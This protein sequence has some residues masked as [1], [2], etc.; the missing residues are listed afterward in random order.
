MSNTYRGSATPRAG[1]VI[2]I[3][4]DEISNAPYG[5]IAA[6]NMQDAINELD[7]EKV[8]KAGD[9]MTGDLTVP[10][11]V[12]AGN[13]DGRD[14]SVD[15]TKLDGIEAL[16]DVTDVTNVTAAGALMDSEVDAGIKTLVLPAS[17][18]ISTFGASLVDDAA[19]S[20]ARTTLGLGTLAVEN[21]APITQGGTG[22]PTAQAAIDA[23]SSVSAATN[24]HVLTKDT[25]TG[26]AIF[27]VVSA[28]VPAGSIGQSE[29]DT[30]EL[31]PIVQSVR[32]DDGTVA[33]GTTILP[34]D[35][36]IPQNTEGDEYLTVTITPRE[37]NNK[38]IIEGLVHVAHSTTTSVM[39]AALFKDSDVNAL[40]AASNSKALAVDTRTSIPINHELV[41]GGVAAITF[42]IRAGGTVAGTTTFNGSVG[43]QS[44]G[45]VYASYLKVTEIVQ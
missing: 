16:A 28:P 25:A 32:T 1:S 19:A 18:T 30:A 10:N 22:Q 13:V 4:A 9:T 2:T 35:N 8:A 26:N 45:G 6:E 29:I 34:L 11:L 43:A 24:E 21:T 15:G 12:T 39:L 33:T 38:L 17:T 3:G 40:A 7:D 23:L 41:A 5:D 20:N 31:N 14:V 27:K 44:F 42:K 36:T 37:A